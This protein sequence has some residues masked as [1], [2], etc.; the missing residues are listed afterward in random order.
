MRAVIASV[1]L[2]C[3]VWQQ[4]KLRD[5]RDDRVTHRRRMGKPT[6][7]LT[8]Y[9]SGTG[10]KGGREREGGREGGRERGADTTQRLCPPTSAPRVNHCARPPS[11]SLRTG[12]RSSPTTKT[13]RPV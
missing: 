12:G 8:L 3:L 9:F 11:R 1:H 13:H 7:P 6:A 5:K 10:R 4:A 2:G